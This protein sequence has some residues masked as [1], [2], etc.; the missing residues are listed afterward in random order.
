MKAWVHGHSWLYDSAAKSG[1]LASRSLYGIDLARSRH[2]QAAKEESRFEKGPRWDTLNLSPPTMHCLPL[3]MGQGWTMALLYRDPTWDLPHNRLITSRRM[4]LKPTRI[5][6]V[7]KNKSPQHVFLT[8]PPRS[9][10][11]G[12]TFFAFPSSSTQTPENPETDTEKLE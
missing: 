1:H 4:R 6:L 12:L 8:F 9:T 2:P 5:K 7:S 11:K 10:G 3:K